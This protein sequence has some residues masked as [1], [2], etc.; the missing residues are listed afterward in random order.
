MLDA[1]APDFGTLL[2]KL[3]A[4]AGLSQEQLAKRARISVQAVG[5]Y[6]R[7]TRR[8]PQRDTFVLI[9]EALKIQGEE[10]N[11]L[12]IAAERGRLRG[13]G[14]QRLPD[15]SPSSERPAARRDNLPRQLPE[16]IGRDDIVTSL[17]SL[18]AEK[19][20]VTL[21][22]MG[23]IGKSRTAVEV[24][25]GLV[26]R[27]RDGVWF[28]EL[29]SLADPKLVAGAVAFA[30]GVAQQADTPVVETLQRRLRNKELLL[31]LDNCEHLVDE[32]ARVTKAILIQCPLVR[33]L[34]TSREQLHVSGEY[35]YRM[36]PLAVDDAV[37]L[38]N[39]RA[40]SADP[41]FDAT[42]GDGETIAAICKRLD[43]IPLAIELAAA[44]VTDLPAAR[45][46]RELDER[47]RVLIA[48]G[49]DALPRQKT[50]RALIDW[51]YDLLTDEERRLLRRLSLFAG[52]WTLT[53]ATSL[54]DDLPPLSGEMAESHEVLDLLG[55]LVD[56]SL[57]VAQIGDDAQR[58]DLLEST[59]AYAAERLDELNE[60]EA[61]AR[62]H[63]E[64][65]AALAQRSR[66][67][68]GSKHRLSLLRADAENIRAALTWSLT[69]ANAPEIA[70]GILRDA[71]EFLVQNF[72]HELVKHTREV[73]AIARIGPELKAE[74]LIEV[75][76]VTL[77]A[78]ALDAAEGAIKVL[79]GA[80]L[81]SKTL[82]QAYQR[83]SYALAQ[84][85]R[86]P[87]ALEAHRLARALYHELGLDD[88]DFLGSLYFQE[89][90]L[91]NYQW[92][93]EAART[94]WGKAREISTAR[95][96]T[97]RAAVTQNNIAEAFF[98][99]GDLESA[100]RHAGECLAV[101]RRENL[102]YLEA[103]TLN[104]MAVYRLH[105]NDPRGAAQ[106]LSAAVDAAQRAGDDGLMVARAVRNT[107]RLS[108]MQHDFEAAAE[109]L[110]YSAAW[111]EARRF[112]DPS[113][114]R[115]RRD[116]EALL[117]DRLSADDFVRL[118]EAGARLDEDEAW[119]M[120][121][122]IIADAKQ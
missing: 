45:L 79:G 96:D 51:S 32:A 120:A 61:I 94:A 47:F 87:E 25:A 24:A 69:N 89:G 73:L 9:V 36:P 109:L 17:R 59:R 114:E 37:A 43:G 101:F 70:A 33:V 18:L 63:A 15:R 14:R 88:S 56:K 16:L 93:L 27:F 102:T 71:R 52:G 44:R 72:R 12:R 60:R 105:V 83:R 42:D 84:L 54:F 107:A 19:R 57:V 95:G 29:A 76:L 77:G 97:G 39:R 38:F 67:I 49:E 110:G 80:G 82:L 26:E 7:G 85:G 68:A 10:Y 41:S 1:L 35:V 55:S 64:F 108:A 2:K 28:V 53:G 4:Q 13:P 8:A 65:V 112:H 99:E 118:T 3:R 116:L 40:R 6:E 34:A 86:T 21:A 98:L 104:N 20:F 91:L 122:S 30:A 50:M 121:A 100:L 92:Q 117:R 119:D 113:D 46:L 78:E 103:T 66:S 11:R 22:G 75:A 111:F 74:M 23:G 90:Y 31:V 58:Y 5:A 106:D 81:R 62:R 48:A 115:E